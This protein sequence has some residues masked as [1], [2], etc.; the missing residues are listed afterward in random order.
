M[1]SNSRW[2]SISAPAAHTNGCRDMCLPAQ[3]IWC[4]KADIWSL[5]VKHQWHAETMTLASTSHPGLDF[6]TQEDIWPYRESVLAVTSWR[7][8]APGIWWVEDKDDIKHPPVHSE[9]PHQKKKW[10]LTQDVSCVLVQ[11]LL[12][13]CLCFQGQTNKRAQQ[14]ILLQEWH[15][16]HQ[17]YLQNTYRKSEFESNPRLC[18]CE[19]WT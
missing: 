16:H 11:L 17:N 2:I 19:L 1:P 14:T 10:Y 9:A 18:E 7:H 15:L 8:V 13:V 3:C 5:L 12:N 6:V 4:W